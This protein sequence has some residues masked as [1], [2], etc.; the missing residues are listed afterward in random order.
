MVAAHRNGHSADLA[1]KSATPEKSA[2]VQRL[3]SGAFIDAELAQPLRFAGGELIPRNA[4][5]IG[6]AAGREKIKTQH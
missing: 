2:P 5:Y 3:D 1:G 6:R 4:V